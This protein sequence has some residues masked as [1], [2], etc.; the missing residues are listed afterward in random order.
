MSRYQLV[1]WSF[2]TAPGKGTPARR[3]P[4]GLQRNGFWWE[5]ASLEYALVFGPDAQQGG[6]WLP[7]I[8]LNERLSGQERAEWAQTLSDLSGRVVDIPPSARL[9]ELT[10][11]LTAS[12]ARP[13]RD[14]NNEMVK[15]GERPQPRQIPGFAGG[16]IK[17]YN[18]VLDRTWSDEADNTRVTSITDAGSTWTEHGD[19]AETDQSASAINNATDTTYFYAGNLMNSSVTDIT[20]YEL[21]YVLKNAGASYYYTEF[22]DG[23]GNGDGYF[24][25]HEPGGWQEIYRSDA[26]AQTQLTT[27][28]TAS[29]I[30]LDDK[31][32]LYTDA[33]TVYAGCDGGAELSSAD[34]TYRTAASAGASDWRVYVAGGDGTGALV[35]NTQVGNAVAAVGRDDKA[36]HIGLNC[37][38]VGRV[39]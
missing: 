35:G 18:N 38:G 32:Y 9:L 39:R 33:S 4:P 6:I 16:A 21:S 13:A 14:E 34:T 7:D 15:V 12:T 25:Y 8:E 1:P 5:T 10:T 2:G 19:G 36:F 30:V 11:V 28:W 31:L 23:G 29:T 27:N 17:N 3:L 24:G 26:F 22:Q 37:R 20:G